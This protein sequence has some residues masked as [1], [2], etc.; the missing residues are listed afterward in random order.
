MTIDDVP[1]SVRPGE[2]R[3]PGPSTR[4]IILGDSTPAPAPI[5]EES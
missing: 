4:D 2:A 3:C 1:V 5:L